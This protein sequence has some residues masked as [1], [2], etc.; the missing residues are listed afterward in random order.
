MDVTDDTAPASDALGNT[1]R[2]RNIG[3]GCFAIVGLAAVFATYL[4]VGLDRPHHRCTYSGAGDT[5]QV[6]STDSC[7]DLKVTFTKTGTYTITSPCPDK[8]PIPSGAQA[9]CVDG[10]TYSW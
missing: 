4:W 2:L 5:V 6:Q 8:A 3:V 9:Y 7:G 10:K 1:R